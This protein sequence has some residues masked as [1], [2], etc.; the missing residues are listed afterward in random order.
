MLSFNCAL[1]YF[2]I[3]LCYVFIICRVRNM[4]IPVELHQTQESIDL[5][6]RTNK[7]NVKN[8]KYVKS[9]SNNVKGTNEETRSKQILKTTLMVTIVY[10]VC[11]SPSIVYY[12]L[13]DICKTCFSL[14]YKCSS[15]EKYIAFVVKYLQFL[16]SIATPSI[17]CFQHTEFKG[18]LKRIYQPFSSSF[19]RHGTDEYSSTKVMF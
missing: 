5:V 8:D 17:Y 1:P 6:N 12:L 19:Q 2:I 10:G 18:S 4:A 3:V 16:N 9:R 14:H 11:W 13:M 7:T 15:Y